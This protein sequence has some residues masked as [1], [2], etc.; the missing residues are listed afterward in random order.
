MFITQKH[1]SRRAA[2][3]GMGV[4]VALPFLEAMVPAGTAFARSRSNGKVR[5]AAIE[6]VHGSAGATAIGAQKHLWSPEKT[7]SAFDLSPS[8]LAPLE[9]W[10]EHLT[11]ISNT[12]VRNAEAFT[13]PEIG[14]DHFRSSAVFLTQAHPKQTQ[15]SDVYVA[16]SL[17]QLYAQKYGQDTPIP[18]MQLCIENVDQAGGCAYGYAC[19]YTDT[20]SWASATEPLPMVRDPRAAFDMLFGVGATPEQRAAR[21]KADKSILDWVTQEVAQLKQSLGPVDRA[22]LADYLDDV[23]EIERRIQRVEAANASGEPRELPMAPMGV[24]D[25]FDEHVKLMFDLQAVAFASDITRVFSFKMGRDGSSRVYPGSGV[26]TGFHPASHHQDREDRILDFE[27]INRYHIS[28]LPYFL[29]KLKN[30]PD[31]DGTLLDNTMVIYGSP[32]G[33]SNVHNHKRCP[34]FLAGHAGGAL[35]GNLHIKAA[36]GTPM[37]NPMLSM[38]HILGLDDVKSFGDSTGEMDLN[39]VGAETTTASSIAD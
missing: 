25:A 17:D 24:P 37:A 14:G 5:L 35:K 3:K 13:P 4:T 10:R 36:D 15:G 23:R 7:G 31:G 1:I 38:L 28:L 21:R 29:E 16:T 19:V 22:R 32:M 2:L 12:D 18:S 20:V 34:L 8:S 6:M 30:T 27:K 26:K 9:P 33:N 11:I 39:A